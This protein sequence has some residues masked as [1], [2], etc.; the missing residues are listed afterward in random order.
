M[1]AVHAAAPIS[2]PMPLVFG[3]RS[4]TR[5]ENAILECC[6]NHTATRFHVQP[7]VT[8]SPHCGL[9]RRAQFALHQGP[10]RHLACLEPPWSRHVTPSTNDATSK[11]LGIGCD[12]ST[13]TLNCIRPHQNLPIPQP[14]ALCTTPTQ[15][16]VHPSSRARA[17]SPLPA[18]SPH[19][20]CA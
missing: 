9:I 4:R 19:P 11:L 16:F 1:V 20:L 3:C 12:H 18:T 5:A 2:L 17:Q 7:A 6:Q 10:S 15:C 14:P 8:L 13:S